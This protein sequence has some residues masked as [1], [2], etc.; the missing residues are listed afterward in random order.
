VLIACVE[1]LQLQAEIFGRGLCN[2]YVDFGGIAIGWINKQSENICRRE[3]LV[4]YFQTLR[5]EFCV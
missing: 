1:N 2:F 4:E 3:K 5:S